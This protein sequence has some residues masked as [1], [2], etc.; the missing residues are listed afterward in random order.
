MQRLYLSSLIC[1]HLLI[2]LTLHLSLM[3][4]T[5]TTKI[6]NKNLFQIPLSNATKSNVKEGGYD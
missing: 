3:T 1:K 2:T 4:T 6:T 5:T